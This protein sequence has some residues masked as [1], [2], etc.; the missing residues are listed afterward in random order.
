MFSHVIHS[1]GDGLLSQEMGVVEKQLVRLMQARGIDPL[2]LRERL[3]ILPHGHRQIPS[4]HFALSVETCIKR[5]RLLLHYRDFKNKTSIREI[6]PQ[7]LVYYRQN[8]Y[9]DAWCHLRKGLRTFAIAR[10]DKLK[11]LK[12]AALDKPRSVLDAHFT[13]SYGIFAGPCAPL[14]E[15]VALNMAK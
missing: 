12:N 10:M 1:L 8:W 14:S 3:K 9:L 13:Q 4:R 7:T 15:T 6:S 2:V 11:L 5:Q